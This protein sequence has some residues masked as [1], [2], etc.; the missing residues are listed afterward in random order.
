MTA[1]EYLQQIR[2][3]D[4]KINCMKARADY[5]DRMSLSI[6]GPSYGEKIGSNPN[7]NLEA[8]FLKWLFKL[9]EIEREIKAKEEEL[10]NHRAEPLIKIE[11]LPDDNLKNVLILRYFQYK[12]WSDIA[13]ELYASI[14]TVYRW[15]KE[16]LDLIKIN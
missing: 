8:P 11:N 9:D 2:N 4:H 3:L 15:H 12:N 13:K 6:P 16:A 10:K 5:Y 1:Q 7:R 14:A